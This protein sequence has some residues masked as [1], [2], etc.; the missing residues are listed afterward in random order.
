MVETNCSQ[1]SQRTGTID[2]KALILECKYV[3]KYYVPDV[4]DPSVLVFLGVCLEYHNLLLSYQFEC[5][6]MTIHMLY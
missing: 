5:C 2:L 4:R 3:I 1:G 6:W